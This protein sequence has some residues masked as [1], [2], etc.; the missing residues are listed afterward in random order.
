MRKPRIEE[1]N[2][3]I[4][5]F[6]SLWKCNENQWIKERRKRWTVVSKTVYSKDTAA[7]RKH[8]NAYFMSGELT[9]VHDQLTMF[10]LTPINTPGI[11]K[12]FLMCDYFKT[13]YCK[14]RVLTSFLFW[15]N[16][17]LLPWYRDHARYLVD[18]VLGS[19]YVEL[20]MEFPH[21]KVKCYQPIATSF[22]C[23]FLTSSKD[24]LTGEVKYSGH[25]ECLD[26]FISALGYAD[27]KWQN[28]E[29]LYNEMFV[30]IEACKGNP[31]VSE[32]GVKFAKIL[33]RKKKSIVASW[34]K[35]LRN[36]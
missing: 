5:P 2:D 12:E 32:D 17:A 24:L 36:T 8:L 21:G 23:N 31:S 35:N 34:R 33:L 26:Y 9:D 14:Q 30:V 27:R 28:L 6:R 18:G 15:R 22:C 29:L 3:I 19:K 16:A 11:A 7:Y 4:E 10:L 25:I 1:L 13:K 20:K